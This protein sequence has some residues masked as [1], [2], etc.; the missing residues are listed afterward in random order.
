MRI[1]LS[2][3]GTGFVCESLSFVN[4]NKTW[5]VTQDDAMYKISMRQPRVVDGSV[6]YVYIYR[7]REIAREREGGR[8]G[9]RER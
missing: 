1:S 8:D 3:F 6:I 2:W 7:E 4:R 9:E 5:L